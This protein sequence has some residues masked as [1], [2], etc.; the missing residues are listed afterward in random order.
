[1]AFPEFKGGALRRRLGGVAPAPA[2]CLTTL[3]ESDGHLVVYATD[4]GPFAYTL[5]PLFKTGDPLIKV[6][7]KSPAREIKI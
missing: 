6:E 7:V 3:L 5:E 1:L 2:L 4:K